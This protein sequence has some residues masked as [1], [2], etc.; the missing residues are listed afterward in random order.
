[1]WISKGH[2]YSV[3]PP[4]RKL[5]FSTAGIQTRSACLCVCVCV[6]VCVRASSPPLAASLS[7]EMGFV[8]VAGMGPPLG[9]R[10][11]KCFPS[12]AGN[13]RNLARIM[14]LAFC[15]VKEATPDSTGY[16]FPVVGQQ[17]WFHRLLNNGGSRATKRLPAWY[18]DTKNLNHSMCKL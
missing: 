18:H 17:F 8:S 1:M 16:R 6:W 10:I 7:S 13:G 4:T 5:S 9:K 12:A 11:G 14:T 15:R 2:L 3:L